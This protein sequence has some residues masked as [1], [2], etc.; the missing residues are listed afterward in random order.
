MQYPIW[1]VP[2]LGGG[3]VIAVIAIVHVTVAHFA[4]GAGLF[5]AVTESKAL[6]RNRPLL[7]RFLKD[8]TKFLVLVSFVFGALTGVGIWFSI[9]LVSP[10]ATSALIHQF[11]WGWATEWVFFFVEI[12]AGYIYYYTWD[13][14]DPVKHNIV[15]W[16]YAVSAFMSLVI[17][18]GILTFML[19]PGE[20]LQTRTFWDGFFNP[21]YWPSLALRTLSSLSLAAIFVTISV[22]LAKQYTREER[23]EIIVEGG[24]WLA[25]LALMIPVSIWYFSQVTPEARDLVMGKAIPMT[26]F[27]LF[28]M[29]AST[30]VG[31]YAYFGLILKK[32]YINLETSI[33]LGL[34]AF[35]ATGSMEFVREGIRKPY[36][37]NGYMYSNAIKVEEVEKLNEDGV[38]PWA[39]WTAVA[40]GAQDAASLASDLRGQAIYDAQCSRCH[41]LDG[42][43]GIKPLIHNWPESSLRHALDTLHTEQYY[44]PPFIGVKQEK[45]DLLRYLVQ[46]SRD[47]GEAASRTAAADHSTAKEEERS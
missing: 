33:L 11:V 9:A 23:R 42:F 16:I 36:I 35:I 18:N 14:M 10:E 22:N 40:L 6:R 15:G 25:P 27:L 38:L 4:V 28:G 12:I 41:T 13:R 44:M 2:M 24:R 39:P 47:G 45:E 8:Y 19:T 46:L 43:N 17:I 3:M 37:I 1:D 5:V 20:W 30:L 26:L 32:R 31:L 29:A 21:T 34:I 7:L